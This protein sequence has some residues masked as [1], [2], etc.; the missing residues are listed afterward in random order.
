VTS[1]GDMNRWIAKIMLKDVKCAFISSRVAH[2]SFQSEG[3]SP[4]STR[5]DV[6]EADKAS[7]FGGFTY[8]TVIMVILSDSYLEMDRLTIDMNELAVAPPSVQ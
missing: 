4:I 2:T 6:Q 8:L 3:S 5:K 1:N 7:V